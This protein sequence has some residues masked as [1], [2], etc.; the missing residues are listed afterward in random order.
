MQAGTYS[1]EI[2][3]IYSITVTRPAKAKYPA[4][5]DAKRAKISQGSLCCVFI[6]EYILRAI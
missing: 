5:N 4:V 3:L 6:S 2:R 1:K